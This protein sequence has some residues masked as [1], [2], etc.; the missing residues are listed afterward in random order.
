MA[1]RGQVSPLRLGRQDPQGL[2]H[3]PQTLSQEA[4]R[5][6]P[7]HNFHRSVK[8]RDALTDRSLT[9]LFFRFPPITAVCGD[10]LSGPNSQGLGV[11]IMRA[12]SEQKMF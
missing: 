2:G 4:R 9:N 10:W 6:Q 12:E 8:C 3:R 11:S 5:P 7:L 1:S